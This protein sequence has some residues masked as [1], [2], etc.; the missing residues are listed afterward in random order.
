MPLVG[1]VP[2]IHSN[3]SSTSLSS[4]RRGSD[5]QPSNSHLPRSIT[6]SSA[7]DRY[8]AQPL[9]VHNGRE[10]TSATRSAVTA[11]A[12]QATKATDPGRVI[13]TPSPNVSTFNSR[14]PFFSR[15]S[16]TTPEP[17]QADKKEKA[18]RKGPA[19]G[20]GHEGYG[21]LGAIRRR[22]ASSTAAGRGLVGP[23]SSQE[24]LNSNQSHDPFILERMHPVVMAGGEIVENRNASSELSRT[25]SNQSLYTDRPSTDSKGSPD[26]SNAPRDTARH[27][28][29]PSA[30]PRGDQLPPKTRRPSD[31]SDSEA[32]TMKSTL[33]F[34]RSVQRLHTAP[35]E[36]PLRLPRPI[37]TGVISS[38]SIN[39]IDT[40]ILSD[41]SQMD[42]QHPALRGRSGSISRDAAA[43]APKKLTKRTRSPRKWNFFSRSQSQPATA[44]KK[45][46]EPVPA[47]VQ[48]V[49]HKPVAFYT[50][51][52]SFEQEE[53]DAVVNIKDVLRDAEVFDTPLPAALAAAPTTQTPPIQHNNS[54]AARDQARTPQPLQSPPRRPSRPDEL[55]LAPLSVLP[56]PA[57]NQRQ[58]RPSRL[59]QV[60][61]IPKVVSA[62][63]EQTSPKSFSRPFNRT[64]FQMRP[65]A[66]SLDN[67]FVAKGPSPPNPST[68]EPFQEPN[69]ST[70]SDN[71][72]H[73]QF[74]LTE[75]G[76]SATMRVGEKEFMSFSPRKNSSCTTGTSSSCSGT[77]NYAESTAIIPDPNG[78]LCDDEVWDEYN[79]LILDENMK[80]PPSATSSRGTPFHL[81]GYV[82]KLARQEAAPLESPTIAV[83]PNR[84]VDEIVETSKAATASSV[85]SADMT[86]RIKAAF[87][88]RDEPNPNPTTPFSV[89]EFVSGYEIRDSTDASQQQQQD[90]PTQRNSG[91][92]RRSRKSDSSSKSSEEESPLMQ[93]NLRVGSMTVSKWLTFGH[94]LLS[95]V[96]EELVPVVGSLKRHS[97]LVVDGLGND[98]WSFYAAETY[99]AATFFNLSP[100]AP[101]PVEHQTSSAFPLSP[102]NHHQI[103][104]LSYLGKFPFGPESFTSVVYRFPAV[105]P[106]SHYRNI[107]SEARRVLKPGGYL[108]LSVLDL[109]LNNMGNRGRRAIRRLKERIHV[110]SPDIS[111]GS[112]SDLVLRLL[113]K[114]GFTDIKTCRVGVPVASS[115]APTNAANGAADRKQKGKIEERSLSEMMRDDG[116]VADENITKMVARVGRWWYSRCY[117]TAGK[118]GSASKSIWADRSLLTEC[119]EWGTSFKLMVCYARVPDNKS[120]VASI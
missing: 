50:M 56:A 57:A 62:R 110:Q 9:R 25:E 4:E 107:I 52:D 10:A 109:D 34:R 73:H 31:S 36:S 27:T 72:T 39:S 106:E 42:V 74:S 54:L 6:P 61:R 44:M 83:H 99:P 118:S 95:P 65:L 103:Q 80:P 90:E 48:V 113:G 43:A 68:P 8:Q 77:M 115:I 14:F 98:D 70:L 16:K 63:P 5:S 15:R 35:D 119:E 38:P 21:R 37:N 41:D 40:T 67:T 18:A 76:L 45:Q 58:G 17:P 13:R 47:T 59:A 49:Q 75:D 120:R 46:T 85:Y 33:A 105:A 7:H 60:G 71:L 30:F 28:L 1:P 23:Q 100:R 93:V 112:T 3:L 89:S 12:K 97:I 94:V 116:D 2:V 11:D 104:Y 101:L 24:S 108:E 69:V 79:D 96:K 55:P 20:T 53:E 78:P 32:I 88:I 91:T 92:S 66:N 87:V 26:M 64:S 82:T 111:L 51:M 86:E 84:T 22:S 102:P 81:E 117:E 29:W 114:K 19:A